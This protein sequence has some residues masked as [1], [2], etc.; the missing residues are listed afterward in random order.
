MTRYPR[1]RAELTAFLRTRRARLSPAD[2]GLPLTERRRTPG[3]RREEV[4]Q[5]AGVGITWYTWLEQG[6]TIEVSAHFLERVARALRLDDQERLHLFTLAQNR[7]PPHGAQGN[8]QVRDAHRR[9]LESFDGPAYI[10]TDCL[11][12]AAW[13]STL[14]ALFGDLAEFEQEDR[15]LLWLLFTDV[16]YQAAIPDWKEAAQGMT[17]RFR[18]EFARRQREPRF[19]ELIERLVAASPEFLACWNQHDVMRRNERPKRFR[20]PLGRII[21]LEQNTFLLEDAPAMRLVVY[22]PADNDSADELRLLRATRPACAVDQ[23]G[24]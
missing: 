2:I 20:S 3:L 10:A 7:P 24:T 14:T 15:N 13:N 16:R 17:A 22:S 8:G 9:M 21:E 19:L 12:V 5:A 23:Q 6:R 18:G 4:A 11:D 1:E